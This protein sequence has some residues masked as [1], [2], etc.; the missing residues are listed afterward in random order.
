MPIWQSSQARARAIIAA[1]LGIVLAACGA[2]DAQIESLPTSVPVIAVPTL[3]P[4]SATPQPSLRG[5]LWLDFALGDVWSID[6]ASGATTPALRT[7]DAFPGQPA[8][9]PDGSTLAHISGARIGDGF[10]NRFSIA[11]NRRVVLREDPRLS[12]LDPAVSPDG[13]RLFA[14]RV[15]VPAERA[16]S[17]VPTSA[18]A[19]VAVPVDGGEVTLLRDDAMQPA[20]SPDG[21]A[22]A[23]LALDVSA[24]PTVTRSL[25]VRDLQTGTDSLVVPDARFY[26]LYGPRWLD[27]Q[28]IVFSAADFTPV[29]PVP[30]PVHIVDALFGYAQ[31]R[32][33]TWTGHIWRVT[34]DG[35]GLT[36]LTLA[37]L[38]APIPAPSPDG[39]WLAILSMEGVQVLPP[40]GGPPLTIT[41]SGGNGGIAWT[42]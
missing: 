10:A 32:A 11:I 30:W 8:L 3:A 26:D 20:V 18:S 7:D 5:R 24:P 23:Y 34:R 42:H 21:R 35:G 29:S 16:E 22:M 13:R 17:R 14:T 27:N 2:P 36:R 19:I 39:R 25:R 4:P 28:T 6:L 37:P 1:H 15:G 31:A 40:D 12:Y 41:T 33:H 38:G 9:T